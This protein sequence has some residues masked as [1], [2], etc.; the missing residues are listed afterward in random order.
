MASAR[1]RSGR[2]GALSLR[3]AALMR[4]LRRAPWMAATAARAATPAS[5]ADAG[6]P[7]CAIL[8]ARGRALSEASMV[9]SGTS[10]AYSVASSM[11]L[12][13]AAFSS[14]VPLGMEKQS[15]MRLKAAVSSS[16]RWRSSS[17][18]FWPSTATSENSFQRA[19]QPRLC[20]LRL[21]TMV[22]RAAAKAPIEAD[23]DPPPGAA[24]SDAVSR[25]KASRVI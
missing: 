21:A 16:M 7:F 12:A 23:T 3:E 20:A 22:A 18:S 19:S 11:A 5:E 13:R 4:T 17:T 24:L 9:R 2:A 8:R 15:M 25:V 10:A 14:S 6:L 1:S